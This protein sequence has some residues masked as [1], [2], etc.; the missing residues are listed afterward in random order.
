MIME[1]VNKNGGKLKPHRTHQKGLSVDFMMP[2]IKGNTPY[3][4]LDKTGAMHYLLAFNGNGEYGK[5]TTVK[6]DFNLMDRHILI[7]NK[8]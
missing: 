3:Y 1:T 8:K 5:D 6:V 4:K 2:L 7:L